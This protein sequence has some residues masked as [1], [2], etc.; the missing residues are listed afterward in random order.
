VTAAAA[1]RRLITQ[2]EFATSAGVPVATVRRWRLEGA[3]PQPEKVGSAWLWDRAVVEGWCR[4]RE[5]TPDVPYDV[6]APA[7]L[8]REEWLQ[9]RQR[10]MGGTDVAAALG[11]D[12]YKSSY[13]LWLDKTGRDVDTAG[14]AAEA[15]NRLEPVIARWFADDHPEVT[16]V[17]CPGV[18]AYRE[19]PELLANPDRFLVDST[20]NAL[21]V[22]EVKAPG[23]YQAK[24]WPEGEVPARYLV[25]VQHYL[26]VTGARR[27]IVRALIGGQ[28]NVERV[29]DRDEELIGILREQARSWWAR[30]IVGDE[31]PDVD[32][33][34]RTTE[35][36]GRLYDVAPGKLVDLDPLEAARLLAERAAA[37]A[38]A[39][40]ATERQ[41][42]AENTLRVLL[43]DA[44]IGMVDGRPLVTW[45]PV[46]SHRVDSKALRAQFPDIAEQV[47]VPSTSRR[48]VIK[49]A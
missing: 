33:A 38:E 4:L 44:E 29:I 18:L 19:S 48:L 24:D 39:D 21:D 22:L 40:A 23:L 11:L 30:H 36:L 37:K 35:V 34:A 10:G 13:T 14:E 47:T 42:A 43:G 49:E 6:I 28:R 5:A 46:T 31:P 41:R 3:C 17:P 27:G 15:G 20:D 12:A 26:G 16:V 32:G 1:E 2:A 45:K 25:Q 8:P 7:G 9:I